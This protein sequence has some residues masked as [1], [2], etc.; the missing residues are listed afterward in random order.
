MGRN[1]AEVL[2][3]ALVSREEIFGRMDSISYRYAETAFVSTMIVLSKA[4][5]R[6]GLV[7]YFMV[8]G[9]SKLARRECYS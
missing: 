9:M 7:E 2:A 6:T 5:Q 8:L 4:N 1:W 3:S